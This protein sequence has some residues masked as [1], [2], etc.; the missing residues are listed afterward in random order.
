M[1]NLISRTSRRMS[2]STQHSSRLQ[3]CFASLLPE[4][5]HS[6]F[7]LR[8]YH[9]HSCSVPGRQI[10]SQAVFCLPHNGCCTTSACISQPKGKRANSP[11]HD[12]CFVAWHIFFYQSTFFVHNFRTSVCTQLKKN[13]TPKCEIAYFL[14]IRANEVKPIGCWSTLSLE[15]Y[16]T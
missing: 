16:V 10:G 5:C 6:R 8:R 15:L 2:F 9:S 11:V 3:W 1:P 4:A 12:G 14:Y 7:S 13:I